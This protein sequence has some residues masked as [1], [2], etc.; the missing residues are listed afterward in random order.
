MVWL[1]VHVTMEQ[2]SCQSCILSNVQNTSF[3]T[4]WEV[5]AGPE[6]DEKKNCSALEV[7]VAKLG[8]APFFNLSLRKGKNDHKNFQNVKKIK[9][10]FFLMTQGSFS[11]KIRFLD[12][13]VCSIT[14]GQTDRHESENRGH[15]SRVLE[16][17]SNVPSTY[18]QGAV[19]LNGLSGNQL[20]FPFS[21]NI[22]IEILHYP[23]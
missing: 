5:T 7:V 1:A 21:C 9:M 23:F 13:K 15:P 8:W 4:A 17:I 22:N 3:H 2:N 16:F 14:R 12:Q 20:L 6:F 10:L 11:P 19:P 18:H